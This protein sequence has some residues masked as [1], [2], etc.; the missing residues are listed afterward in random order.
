[1]ELEYFVVDIKHKLILRLNGKYVG[2]YTLKDA[3]DLNCLIA[4]VNMCE[5][6][7]S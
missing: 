7:L 6:L 2:T 4:D 1:M 3:N 5:R